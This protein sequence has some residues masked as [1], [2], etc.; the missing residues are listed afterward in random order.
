M[1]QPTS[2][3]ITIVSAPWVLPMTSPAV[4][5]GA[6]AMAEG[7]ILAVGKRRDILRCYPHGRE[8]RCST[9][10]MPGLVNAHCHLEL[11]YLAGSLSPPPGAPLTVWIEKLLTCRRERQASREEITAAAIAALREQGENGTVLV[12]DI[13]ND[14]SSE[15]QQGGQGLPEV[16]PMLELLAPSHA[17]AGAALT[18]L[19]ELDDSHVAAAH[20]PYST[21]AEVLRA[22]KQRCRRLGQVFSVHCAESFAEVEFVRGGEGAFARF[23]RERGGGE[24]AFSFASHGFSGSVIYFQSLD[25]LDSAT[26]LVHGVHLSGE[27]LGVVAEHG[28]HVCLCPGSNRFLG[29]GRAPLPE[30]LAAGILPALGTDS[31]ASNPSLDLWREMMLLAED[32][33]RVE[34]HLILAMATVG[35][36][37]ALQRQADYGSLAPGLSSLMLEVNSTALQVCPNVEAV[38]RQLVNGGRPE[39]LRLVDG[40]AQNAATTLKG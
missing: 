2:Q 24:E 31:L 34:P 19:A 11:S 17:A 14:D 3:S 16:L 29:V 1:Q 37:E 6:V 36:A 12:A 13:G 10:L 8:R 23:L 7:K 26:L 33:P 28:S 18:R 22:V 9:V 21:T 39:L 4:S 27:E 40:E 25:L 30:M 5:D 20:A 38:Y 15:L 35:G 32:H